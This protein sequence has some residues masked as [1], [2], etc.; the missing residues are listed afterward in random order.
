[1]FKLVAL[2]VAFGLAV[3]A[4]G[5]PTDPAP[6][7]LTQELHED[8]KPEDQQTTTTEINAILD[9]QIVKIYLLDTT[10]TE[11]S[12]LAVADRTLPSGYSPEELIQT[13]AEGA[14][15]DEQGLGLNSTIPQVPDLIISVESEGGLLVIDM[16]DDFWDL[17]G[18]DRRVAA[19]QM[20]FTA[21]ESIG[22]DRV[23]LRRNGEPRA[24]PEAD[25]SIS[26][27]PGSLTIADFP[28]LDPTKQRADL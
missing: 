3:A 9:A 6:Q 8:L 18:S 4:C 23:E 15:V 14:T 22:V 17:E 12:L 28:E 5:I 19:A 21:V 24:I 20:V 13:V 10:D 27:D 16:T 7:E 11:R 25:G 26:D 2:L 1:M